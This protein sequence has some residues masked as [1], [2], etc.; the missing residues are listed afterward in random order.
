MQTDN[1][2][3]DD[4]A[5]DCSLW[6]EIDPDKGGDEEGWHIAQDLKATAMG[7]LLHGLTNGGN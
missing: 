4:I 1:R 3:L 7:V 6:L 2:L 5:R